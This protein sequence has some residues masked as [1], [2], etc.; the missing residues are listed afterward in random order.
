MSKLKGYGPFI[1]RLVLGAIFILHGWDKVVGMYGYFI[2][3][4][5]WGFVGMVGSLQY[6][7][8]WPPLFWAICATLAEF[9]GGICVLLGFKTRWAAGAIAIVM[10]VAMVGFH[11]PAGDNVEKHLALFAMGVSLIAS[12]PGRWSVKIEK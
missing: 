4:A 11:I 12:G 7:P 6:V 10:F 1:L 5:E 3:G 9:V 8:T 2:H